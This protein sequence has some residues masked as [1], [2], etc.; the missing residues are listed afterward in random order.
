AGRFEEAAARAQ[1][2]LD[3]PGGGAEDRAWAMVT[4]GRAHARA[5][6]PA[7]ATACLRD[8]TIRRGPELV[9]GLADYWL[10]ILGRPLNGRAAQEVLMHDA[11]VELL[12]FDWE[13]AEASLQAA[14]DLDPRSREA[15]AMLGQVYLSKFQYWYDFALLDRELFPGESQADPYM[16]LYLQDKGR[17]E[18]RRADNLAPAPQQ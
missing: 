3:A 11:E 5:G 9:R 10:E 15:H 7:A 14:L 12:G 6:R 2:A 4:L 13:K 8:E 1:Q 17:E 16:Y 18:L